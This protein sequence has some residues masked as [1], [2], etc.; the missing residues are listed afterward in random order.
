ML[1]NVVGA[2]ARARL[3]AYSD[4]RASSV[5]GGFDG[6]ATPILEHEIIND[7]GEA[8][9]DIDGLSEGRGFQP[10]FDLQ[11]MPLPVV[12][13]SFFLSSRFLAASRSKGQPQD[14][15]RAEIAGRRVGETIER[16]TIGT[17]TP[18]TYGS[19]SDYV[20]TSKVYGYTT[21]PDRITKT[22][23]T[24][25]TGSNSDAIVDDVLE[26]RSILYDYNFFGPFMLY[27]STN[28]DRF[29]DADYVK[30][31][32]AQGLASP[33]TTLR[34]RLRRIEG[35][36][37]IRRL[38]YLSGSTYTM[39]LVQMTSDVCQA[40]NGMEITTIQWETHGGMKLNFKVLGIQA[41]RIR[42]VHISGTDTVVR[43]TGIL[44]ATD[45]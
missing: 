20:N 26:M 37:D 23:L 43:K 30:G 24:A 14:T 8:I 6:M 9:V 27:H 25:P 42:S 10:T 17:V 12:H 16:M 39:L 13:S 44:H 41:P 22:D 4:L 21:H 18:Y 19:S 36:S 11:G 40:V 31:S 32:E 2:A 7:P 38:D 5:L 34:D 1:D 28:W 29:L 45:S 3:R 35:I 33:G 15:I